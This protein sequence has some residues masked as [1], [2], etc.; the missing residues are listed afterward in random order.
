MKNPCN[1]FEL[2]S[3]HICMLIG[4]NNKE[5]VNK[6]IETRIIFLPK[7]SFELFY[8]SNV[9]SINNDAICIHKLASIK[10][11]SFTIHTG[12]PSKMV[13]SADCETIYTT[14]LSICT[15]STNRSQTDLNLFRGTLCKITRIAVHV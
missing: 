2:S 15:Q 10:I 3:V 7:L 9:C 13:G 11:V 4:I 12:R 14:Y 5:K 1:I 6:T 8:G